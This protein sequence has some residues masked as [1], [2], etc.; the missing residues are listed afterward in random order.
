MKICRYFGGTMQEI[1]EVKIA[2]HI[3]IKE[4]ACD[5]QLLFLEI[6][7]T[8]GLSDTCLLPLSLSSGDKAES[9]VIENP[10]AV[11]AHFRYDHAE[12]I[13]YDSIYD[14]AFRKHL[15]GMFVR[16]H[17]FHGLH[18]E[19]ITTAGKTIKKRTDNDLF[20]LKSH[21]TKGE[22]NNSSILYGKELI[23]K[24][25]RRLDEGINPELEICK[26]LTDKISFRHVPPLLGA[27]EY[28]RHGGGSV[29]LGMLQAFVPNEGDAWT[30]TLDWR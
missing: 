26:F 7:Y 2:E 24:L 28:K 13:I 9:I 19:L 3:I 11:V 12:G 29:T 5:V 1:R 25:Y 23:C 20:S 6:K 22:Q 10:H 30:Y 27:I 17:T 18:G 4:N 16:R 21:V 8:T 14:E 15:L